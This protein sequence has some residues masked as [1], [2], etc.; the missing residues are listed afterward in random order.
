MPQDNNSDWKKWLHDEAENNYKD[1]NETRKSSWMWAIGLIVALVAFVGLVWGILNRIEAINAQAQSGNN[2]PS[3]ISLAT[4]VSEMGEAVERFSTAANVIDIGSESDIIEDIE[5]ET[6]TDL[7]QPEPAETVEVG[8][9][10]CAG[11]DEVE[12]EILGEPILTPKPGYYYTAGSPEP[13]IT[14]AWF[15][16]NAGNCYWESIAFLS[17]FDGRII[18]PIIKVDGEELD[19]LATGGKLEISPGDQIELVIPYKVT[20]AKNVSDE[21]IIVVNGVSLVSDTHP[22]IQV[23]EWVVTILA[24]NPT[25]TPKVSQPPDKNGGDSDPGSGQPPPRPTPTPPR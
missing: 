6:V 24:Q 17:I 11:L 14:A 22:M 7:N 4:T 25:S 13:D 1:I 5:D 19:L 20:D 23:N 12:Y 10:A 2:E 18:Y 9:S 3:Q 21:F 16:E 8:I 15:I